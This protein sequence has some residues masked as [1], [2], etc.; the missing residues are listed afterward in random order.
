MSR[1]EKDRQRLVQTI[2]AKIRVYM[3]RFFFCEGPDGSELHEITHI[4]SENVR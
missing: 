3:S 1:T 4:T 2:Q